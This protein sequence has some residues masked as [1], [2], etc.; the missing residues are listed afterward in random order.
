MD[1]L[2]ALVKK[3][4]LEEGRQQERDSHST[5]AVTINQSG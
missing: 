3:E 5:N 1:Q 2:I 4:A